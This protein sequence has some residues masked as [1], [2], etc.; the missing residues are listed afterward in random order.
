M[1]H[2]LPSCNLFV[3][4][5]QTFRHRT[6]LY[7]IFETPWYYISNTLSFCKSSI[8]LIAMFSSTCNLYFF[9]KIG[10]HIFTREKIRNCEICYFNG[11]VR[12][13]Y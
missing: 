12:E 1:D 5:Q 6:V 2:V 10:D 8:F 3:E 4:E 13:G 7:L 11:Q 9:P